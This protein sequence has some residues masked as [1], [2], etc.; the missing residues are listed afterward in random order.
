MTYDATERS[1]QDGTPAELFDIVTPATT[2]R[3]TT[4]ETDVVFG[5]NTYTAVTG[6][7]SNLLVPDVQNTGED[8]VFEI[9]AEHVL[10]QTYAA[11]MPPYQV[12][13][14]AT[15][16]HPV[17]GVGLQCW[18]GFALGL[19][20]KKGGN[21]GPMAAFVVP[22]GALSQLAL[23]IPAFRA[24]RGC[25]HVLYDTQ[26]TISRADTT[27]FKDTTIASISADGLTIT[28]TSLSGTTIGTAGRCIHGEIVHTPTGERRT[29]TGQNP[30]PGTAL[31][32]QCAFPR[33]S[34]HVGD[35]VT[36]FRGCDH[37][38]NTCETDF[39]NA[40]NFGGYPYLPPANIF[41]VGFNLG[42]RG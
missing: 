29:I 36:V 21:E 5:G 41:Y 28:V 17:S 15:R 2:F 13:V 38:L 33:N 26:C 42:K 30:S 25:Q 31:T 19:S 6:S 34:L 10:A 39:A 3:I 24:S 12:L 23:D 22:D 14:T 18:K 9:P 8:L 11:G 4:H 20:F 27:R 7:R 16:Y 1:I 35:A 37:T 32:I 40:L